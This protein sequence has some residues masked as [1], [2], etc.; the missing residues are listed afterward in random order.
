MLISGK[1]SVGVFAN[2]ERA[3]QQNNHRE[4]NEG[5][6]TPE[7]KFD[8]PHKGVLGSSSAFRDA[9]GAADHTYTNVRTLNWMPRRRSSHARPRCY[10]G[11]RTGPA[12][13]FYCR[14]GGKRKSSQLRP[15]GLPSLA[16]FAYVV[17]AIGEADVKLS[18]RRR[19]GEK[20]IF[21]Q[22][23]RRHSAGTPV[24]LRWRP[25]GSK[26][27]RKGRRWQLMWILAIGATLVCLRG[28]RSA[29][30]PQASPETYSNLR[31]RLIGPF[32]GG[33]VTSVTGIPGDHST[34]YAGTPGGGVWKT[35]DGG[36]VWKPIFD[37]VEVASVGAVA[38]AASDANRVYVG[39]GEQTPGDGVWKFGRCGRDVDKH[40]LA[41]HAVHL[42]RTGEPE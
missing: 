2:D 42:D 27:D 22:Q 31:W 6:R 12:G 28:A 32:R 19:G 5:I 29:Q 17:D 4:N 30:T 26:R 41:R 36:Q 40:R 23:G 25:D 3:Q 24:G 15:Y 20:V 13:S 37:S 39:T 11:R 16:R 8:Y 38:V 10:I 7:R 14:T 34:Y 9:E 21:G 18:A 35:I 33:R 1:M